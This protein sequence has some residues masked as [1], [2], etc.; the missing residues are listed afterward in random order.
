MLVLL[1]AW[2][3]TVVAGSA[4]VWHYKTTPGIASGPPAT[5][6]A[7]VGLRHA[8][9]TLVVT[10]HP[11]CSCSQA[12]AS[13]LARLIASL[14]ERRPAVYALFID[15]NPGNSPSRA[16]LRPRN[17][18]LW[19]RVASIPG[20]TVV[21]DPEGRL[22]RMFRAETSGDVIA[23][24]A[25]GAL[26][27]HGGLTAARGHEGDSFGRQRLLAVLGGGTPDSR[28][29]PVFGCALHD[30]DSQSLTTF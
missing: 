20:V 24:S 10:F 3:A 22:T 25:S 16:E 8:G 14:G 7:E 28:T 21:A 2:V 13:E 23:Y 6:P 17:S 11:L 18:G 1:V 15:H 19:Q 9:N 26:L 5:W 4:W 27:F 12:T 30:R 29:S